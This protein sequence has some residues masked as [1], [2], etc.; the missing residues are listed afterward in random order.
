MNTPFGKD[1][2]PVE[3]GIM[4]FKMP[5]KHLIFRYETEPAM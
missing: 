2:M 3:V 5:I 1:K 4:F